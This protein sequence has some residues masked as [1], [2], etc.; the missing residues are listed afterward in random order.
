MRFLYHKKASNQELLI[1]N[2]DYR[3]LFKVRLLK[4]GDKIDIRNLNDSFLYLYEIVD[5]KKKEAFLK[6]IRKQEVK[7]AKQKELHLI[8]CVVDIKI[9]E[10]IVPMLNQ[11][12]L[13]KISFV[14]C[15]RSQKNFKIDLHRLEKIL[16]NSSQQCGRSDLTEIEI[17]KNIDE[18]LLMYDDI[19][20]LDFGGENEWGEVKRILIGPEGGFDDKER[21]RLSKYKKVSFKTDFILKSETAA[22]GVCAKLLI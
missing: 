6:L 2:E 18:A 12:G 15:N 22:V 3:Y 4:V 16:I 13:K 7:P 9:V 14:Y 17:L 10:K 8:W 5:V 21:K 20:V 19:T 11:T 1:K